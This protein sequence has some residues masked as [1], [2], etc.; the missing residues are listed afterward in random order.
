MNGNGGGGSGNG[1]GDSATIDASTGHPVLVSSDTVT[2]TNAANRDYAQ[3][4]YAALDGSFADASSGF[5]GTASDGLVQLD[6]SHALTP[7]VRRRRAATSSRPRAS[8]SA[9]TARRFSRSASARRRTRRS[10]RPKGSLGAGFDKALADYKKG[11]KHYDDSLN[12]PPH[13]LGGIKGKTAAT[14]SRTSTT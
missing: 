5:A 2:A 6:A 4:V 8:R 10:A 1:G 14:S 9:T 11:W 7:D 13:K 3:P 12:K